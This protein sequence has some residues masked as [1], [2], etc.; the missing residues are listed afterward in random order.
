MNS[1]TFLKKH[2]FGNMRLE[3]KIDIKKLGPPRPDIHNPQKGRKFSKDWYE[4]CEWLAGD[5]LT[6]KVY[7]FPCF[8]FGPAAKQK[9]WSEGINDWQH[10]TEKT[11]RHEAADSHIINATRLA[12]LGLTDI[13]ASL[14]Q[15]EQVKNSLHNKEVAHNRYI[16]SRIIDCIKFCGA[17]ELALRGHDETPDSAN[18]GVFL[19]LVNFTA[20][21]DVIIKT[22]L[23]TAT[24]FRGTSNTIQNELL[25]IMLSVC[26][27]LIREEIKATD[28][29][30]VIS[31]DT[32]DVTTQSQNVLVFRYVDKEG[33]VQERFWTFTALGDGCAETIATTVKDCCREV[34]AGKH[35]GLVQLFQLLIFNF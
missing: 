15:A 2:P 16:L 14:S 7:C 24:V 19:G 23:E 25:S 20:E 10:L 17:F 4:K 21:L 32:T 22:H 29:L 3:D 27:D 12:L 13:R 34:L 11:K 28:Y 35:Y 31:D 26:R 18:P 9:A 1:I 8:L 6:E 5:A 30:A 33:S